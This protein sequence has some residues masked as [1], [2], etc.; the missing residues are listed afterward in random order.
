MAAGA[1]GAVVFS[2]TALVAPSVLAPGKKRPAW[3]TDGGDLRTLM[4]RNG[5]THVD[6]L[7]V[8]RYVVSFLYQQAA[9]TNVP[10]PAAAS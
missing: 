8:W 4:A 1:E 5:H 6:I 7:K 3:F 2:K 9:I 10:Q